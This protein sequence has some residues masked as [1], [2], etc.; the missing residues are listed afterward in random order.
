MTTLLTVAISTIV[1]YM[2]VISLCFE[3]IDWI[4]NTRF[5]FV[6]LNGEVTEREAV[7]SVELI[8]MLLQFANTIELLIGEKPLFIRL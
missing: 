7:V 4:N 8:D 6:F 3:L 2:C 1:N 5:T